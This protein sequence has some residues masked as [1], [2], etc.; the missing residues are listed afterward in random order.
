MIFGRKDKVSVSIN[1]KK[2]EVPG[3]NA[4]GFFGGNFDRWLGVKLIYLALGVMGWI[5]TRE[6]LF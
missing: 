3:G 6:L 4:K 5:I 2:L 1:G